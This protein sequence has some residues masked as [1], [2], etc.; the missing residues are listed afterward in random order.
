MEDL[1]LYDPVFVDV[2]R[3]WTTCREMLAD[4]GYNIP[5]NIKNVKV[6]EFLK[7]FKNEEGTLDY[8]SIDMEAKH[9]NGTSILVKFLLD[10]SI[11]YK[12]GDVAA[13]RAEI[14]EE[15]G[16]DIKVIFVL[17]NKPKS[18]VTLDQNSE[19]FLL[20]ELIINR[21]NHRLVPKHIMLTD[22]EKK[23]LLNTYDCKDTQL[24]RMLTTDFVARYFGAKPGDIFKIL[25]PSPS[26]GFYV[27]FRVV[28]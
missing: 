26:A 3:C 12:A 21:I 2:Y 6:G 19:M 23:E 27:S 13:A 5:L 18:N 28:K 7:L 14:N 22:T 17:K 11:S 24:P 9:S 20:S 16:E 25:R 15:Q 8:N 10:P 1:T 4:R